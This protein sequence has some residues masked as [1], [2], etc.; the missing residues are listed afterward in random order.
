MTTVRYAWTR[1][2]LF[3]G[4]MVVLAVLLWMLLR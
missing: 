2:A 4:T 1:F 3:E